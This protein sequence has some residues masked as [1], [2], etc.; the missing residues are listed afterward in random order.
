MKGKFFISENNKDFNHDTAQHLLGTHT[1]GTSSMDVGLAPVQNLQYRLED[2]VVRVDSTA[3][4]F[5]F[6]ALGMI[7]DVGH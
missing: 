5:K 1:L 6:L 2:G 3:E 4:Q 7:E